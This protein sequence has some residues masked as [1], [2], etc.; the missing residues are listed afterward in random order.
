MR[1]SIC[2]K[3]VYCDAACFRKDW[4]YHK[5]ICEKPKFSESEA[6]QPGVSSASASD[7]ASPATAP[8]PAA[9]PAP[10]A[11]SDEVEL[12][13]E[14]LA[15]IADV[16]KKGYAY[17]ARKLADSE[18]QA[19]GDIRPKLAT[20]APPAA[21]PSAPAAVAAPAAP[22]GGSAAGA[23]AG[24]GAGSSSGGSA[25]RS[26]A[27][28]W[29]AG[30]TVEE[31]DATAWAR[32]R[33]KELLRERAGELS[34][35]LPGLGRLEVLGIVGW[36]DSSLD[37][38]ISRGKTRYLYDLHVGFTVELVTD[39]AVAAEP[40]LAAPALACAPGDVRDEDSAEAEARGRRTKQ[41]RAIVRFP[42]VSNDTQGAP[43]ELR[44]D[45]GTPAPKDAATRELITSTLHDGGIIT[46][47]R[48]VV[49]G[50]IAE[51]MAR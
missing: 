44:V 2:R 27:S 5:R 9:A 38:V 51:F 6:L 13:A 46:C 48:A 41:P 35:P 22:V 10:A 28:V 16:K 45:W 15:A 7:A 12:D 43:R 37:V 31:R 34:L 1:C 33:L 39:A 30:G 4:P 25:V 42:E 36:G 19:I 49:E 29:N 23:C 47:L 50:L 21:L 11:A 26:A 8:K 18:V 40:A 14:D 24:E 32:G 20:P 17:H 3:K